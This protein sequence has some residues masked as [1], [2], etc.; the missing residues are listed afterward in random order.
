MPIMGGSIRAI[1]D[2]RLE[3]G[4]FGDG[5]TALTS[6]ILGYIVPGALHHRITAVAQP[7][8]EPL[9]GQRVSYPLPP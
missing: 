1:I 5:L 2:N 9:M 3:A 8:R 6:D 7:G 4:R